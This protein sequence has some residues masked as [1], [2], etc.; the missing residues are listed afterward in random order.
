MGLIDE[1][2]K[3]L[4]QTLERIPHFV[5]FLGL[6]TIGFS[7]TTFDKVFHFP[8]AKP[9]WIIFSV[10]IGFI[11]LGI[12]L[13]LAQLDK[14]TKKLKDKS[15]LKFN[16]TIL[17]IKIGDIQDE[18]EL[19]NDSAFV[20]PANTSFADDC[21][22][23]TKSALGAFFTKHYPDKI[24]TFTQNL[25]AILETKNMKPIEGIHY[26]PST[27]LILPDEYSIKSKVIL[28]ASSVR[29]TGS[30]FRTD[31][32]IISNCIFN[33]FKETADKRIST[34]YLPI[35][36]SGHAGLDITEALNLLILSIKFHSKSFHH[37]K[38]VYIFV[39]ERD[40]NK[41]NA[42]FLNCY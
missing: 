38:N 9:N 20:L 16:S 35:I 23:D 40:K 3:I 12:I 42:S 34:F 15:K 14:K 21:V 25:Q 39:R 11:I 13:H 31:P 1:G 18:N 6:L 24:P 37:P 2:K 41:I 8:T 22:T 17:T 10:G 32:S 30:G 4:G 28:M 5:I 27:I 19:T 26:E 7:F 29:S 36:G 33:L